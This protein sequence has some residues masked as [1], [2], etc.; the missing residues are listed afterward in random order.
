MVALLRSAAGAGVD[1]AL[2]TPG[3]SDPWSLKALR[4]GMGAQFRLPVHSTPSWADTSTQLTEWGCAVRA[5]DAGGA[6]THFDVDWCAASALVVGSEAHGLSA[7]VRADP[8]VEICRI[9]LGAGL[10]GDDAHEGRA[11]LESLNAAVAGSVILFEAQ[12]QRVLGRPMGR[13]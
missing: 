9:P 11:G 13:P 6:L 4:A 1:A 12:R 5:A 8:R 10:A 2:L 3:C 7:A